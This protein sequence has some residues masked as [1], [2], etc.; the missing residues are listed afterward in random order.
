MTAAELPRR[1]NPNPVLVKAYGLEPIRNPLKEL[2][3]EARIWAG[4]KGRVHVIHSYMFPDS[5]D[6]CVSRGEDFA[7]R[8][9]DSRRRNDSVTMLETVKQYS[10]DKDLENLKIPG[11]RA[12]DLKISLPC[13]YQMNGESNFFWNVPAYEKVAASKTPLMRA[14]TRVATLDGLFLPSRIYGIQFS[15]SQTPANPLKGPEDTP[16]RRTLREMEEKGYIS[17]NWMSEEQAS[18]YRARNAQIEEEIKEGKGTL[19]D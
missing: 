12:G 1:S 4:P 15:L 17:V 10:F 16:L 2:L 13:P 18:R 3:I 9:D 6:V 11:D 19:F 8:Y 14:I 5:F 7:V